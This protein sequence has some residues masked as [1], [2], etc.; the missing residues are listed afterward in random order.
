MYTACCVHEMPIRSLT[1][2]R[3]RGSKCIACFAFLISVLLGSP[4]LLAMQTTVTAQEQS[5]PTEVEQLDQ[6]LTD[7]ALE[8]M[9]LEYTDE[10]DWGQQ[11]ERWDGVR[12]YLKDGKIRT[13][14]RKKTV[15][16]G[17][18]KRYSASLLDPDEQFSVQ[19]DNFKEVG[20]RSTAFDVIV[21][22]RIKIEG[23]QAKW[24]KGVQLYSISADGK[25]DLRL[26]VSV[27]LKSTLDITKFP[28][29][30]ILEPSI[31]EADIEL[32]D[33]QIDRVS[34]AGGEFAQQLTKAVRKTVDKK[35]AASEQKLVT[36]MNA[37]IEANR[38]RLTL[39]AQEAM[40]SKWAQLVPGEK[41]ESK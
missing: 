11:D 27:E 38:D 10:K 8:N 12:V 19:L 25:A 18:W 26:T 6:F 36:K 21:S 17:T 5:A 15:N 29:D 24:V 23:R 22:A 20:D 35:I 4:V 40:K 32:I 2:K 9:P 34:K 7:L 31:S 33:F 3:S 28:P 14:R 30:L 16:H 41:D 37:K 39:S 1:I 13:K